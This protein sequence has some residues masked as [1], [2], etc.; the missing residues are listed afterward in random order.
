MGKIGSAFLDAN[1]LFP[2]ME[3]QLV[4]GD[5][6]N[7]PEGTGRGYGVVLFYRGHW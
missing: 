5:L 3:I 1:D 2:E 7:L 6:L 4:S